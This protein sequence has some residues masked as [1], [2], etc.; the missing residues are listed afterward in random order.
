MVSSTLSPSMNWSQAAS[1]L[2]KLGVVHVLSGLAFLLSDA[3]CAPSRYETGR[4][5]KQGR[6]V[7]AVFLSGHPGYISSLFL[8]G[9]LSPPGS[10]TEWD[11]RQLSPA[12][13][14]ARPSLGPHGLPTLLNVAVEAVSTSADC[15]GPTTRAIC[16]A[17]A[18]RSLQP[19]EN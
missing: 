19:I 9:L 1:L 4:E 5:E 12:A 10:H 13:S 6:V 16:P 7:E 17:V 15:L 14:P 11:L 8:P 2:W 18:T 3:V